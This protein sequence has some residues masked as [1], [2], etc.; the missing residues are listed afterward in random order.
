MVSAALRSMAHSYARRGAFGLDSDGR[1]RACYA[2]LRGTWSG[3]SNHLNEGERRVSDD[4]DIASACVVLELETD[5]EDF[6]AALR[7]R[8]ASEHAGLW[9]RAAKR[10]WFKV[11]QMSSEWRDA[12]PVPPGFAQELASM[13]SSP[14]RA[15]VHLVVSAASAVS[16]RAVDVTAEAARLEQN[17]G[18]F[19]ETPGGQA[20]K[21]HIDSRP[22]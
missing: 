4:V 20:R 12:P 14:R 1:G 13:S 3:T 19:L 16:G 6:T 15:A 8:E 18:R 21:A 5:L 11:F 22:R 17:L 9:T 7:E 2:R 10:L